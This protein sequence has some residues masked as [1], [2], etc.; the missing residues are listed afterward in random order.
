MH[1]CEVGACRTS[2][3]RG[4]LTW[5]S[6]SFGTSPENA[7]LMPLLV[8]NERRLPT[9]VLPLVEAAPARS[10]EDE[11][12]GLHR[13]SR[14][15][16]CRIRFIAACFR[17]NGAR[18]PRDLLG[19]DTS[20]PPPPSTLLRSSSPSL[21]SH[22]VDRITR[23]PFTTA[24]AAAAMAQVRGANSSSAWEQQH[25]GTHPAPHL[26]QLQNLL[27]DQE[28]SELREV[29]VA[30]AGRVRVRACMHAPPRN[31]QTSMHACTRAGL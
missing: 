28:V 10:K 8:K 23:T 9:D 1:A 2:P 5:R 14:P 24:V 7:P 25:T 17:R 20:H 21:A 11:A 4:W 15:R 3:A 30:A 16:G 31:S 19:S 13:S 18:T 27:S 22:R 12:G 29:R 26:L 6:G